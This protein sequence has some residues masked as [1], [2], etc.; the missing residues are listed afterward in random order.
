MDNGRR[1][2]SRRDMRLLRRRTMLPYYL[3]SYLLTLLL[4]LGSRNNGREGKKGRRKK[5]LPYLP[6][7]PCPTANEERQSKK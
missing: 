2:H 4:L 5:A 1:I 7:L 3:I 6:T